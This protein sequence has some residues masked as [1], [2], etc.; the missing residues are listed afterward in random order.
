MVWQ[1][2]WA[3]YYAGRMDR[4]RNLCSQK[5]VKIVEELSVFFLAGFR[6]CVIL[7]L[8]M[9][10]Q[11]KRVRIR[12]VSFSS[13]CNSFI[14]LFVL[15]TSSLVCNNR[16]CICVGACPPVPETTNDFLNTSPVLQRPIRWDKCGLFSSE[17][18]DDIIKY[19]RTVFLNYVD[20]NRLYPRFP[21]IS[22][23]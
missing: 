15:F 8:N 19:L 4:L 3:D 10:S 18:I 11:C 7:L 13:F 22:R 17:P 1:R 5:P 12:V 14:L 9:V 2:C 21:D 23:G 6:V 16:W 20:I